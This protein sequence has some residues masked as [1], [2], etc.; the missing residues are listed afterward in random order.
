[1]SWARIRDGFLPWAGLALGTVG[2]FLAH[3]IGSDATVQDCRVGSPWIVALGTLIGLA[4]IGTGAFGSWRVY[5]AEGEAPARRLVAIVGLL[6]SALY[7]IGVVLPFV[8]ALVIPR[9]WA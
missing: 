6:A 1:M 2:F 7:V 4:V 8:A 3:Q 5:A 9:C